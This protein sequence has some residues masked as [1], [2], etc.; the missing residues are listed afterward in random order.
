MY[1]V[2]SG[3]ALGGSLE[4]WRHSHLAELPEDVRD[5]MLAEAFVVT[6]PAGNV[7]GEN[8]RPTLALIHSGLTRVVLSGPDG[9][10]AT[11]RYAGAGQILGL[12]S[13]IAN[14][15]P[16]LGYAITECRITF[17]NPETLR[18]FGQTDARVAWSLAR[19]M[20][21]V[22]YEVI[23]TLGANVFGTID[24]RVSRHLLELAV[25]QPEGLVVM[26]DQHELAQSVGS[27]RE[28]VAR[29][30]RSLRE[31]GVLRRLPKGGLLIVRPE[32]L[33]GVAAGL[34]TSKTSGE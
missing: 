19:Q 25:R 30:L 14:G 6:V 9:R 26:A 2:H 8:N 5:A 1:A 10:T 31:R 13:A 24:Q 29:S 12:T 20:A 21:R 16:W 11:V 23:D 22:C 27:V 17:L 34:D 3:G 7:I 32:V 15:S 33:E 4:A 18:R 28:V